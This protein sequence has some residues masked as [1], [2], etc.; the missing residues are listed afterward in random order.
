MVDEN[1]RQ[2]DSLVTLLKVKGF[3]AITPKNIWLKEGMKDPAIIDYLR[4]NGAIILTNNLKDFDVRKVRQSLEHK[5]KLEFQFCFKEG[6]KPI[7]VLW[8]K[9]Q[10]FPIEVTR[11]LLNFNE[12]MRLNPNIWNESL[13]E[14]HGVIKLD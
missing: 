11:R 6:K 13:R 9:T 2:F 10:Q 1:V 7:R 5:H 3:N 14:G 8:L 12:K 4:R